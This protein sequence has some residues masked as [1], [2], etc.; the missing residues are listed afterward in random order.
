MKHIPVL[1]SLAVY[2]LVQN[3]LLRKRGYVIGNLAATGIALLWARRSGLEWDDLGMDSKH[4]VKGIAL[5]TLASASA[6]G[7]A[8]AIGNHENVQTVVDD[9][10]LKGLES[11]E[12]R[13]RL[14]VRFPLGT[15]LFEEVLFRGVLPA[16]FRHHTSARADLI[17]AGAFAAWHVIPTAHAVSSNSRGRSLSRN[18]KATLVLVGSAAAGLAGLG[19]SGMRRASSSLAAPWMTHATFNGLAFLKAIRS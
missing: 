19:L 10:R 8:V 14:M 4:L 7:S 17:S 6:S 1:V 18:R 13:Y 9:E 16:V 15:A 11:G 2:N 5:G 3:T 12:I